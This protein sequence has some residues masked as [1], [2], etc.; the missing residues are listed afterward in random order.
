MLGR[1]SG[2][3]RRSESSETEQTPPEPEET[4]VVNVSEKVAQDLQVELS[5]RG[6]RLFSTTDEG[7][8]KFLEWREVKKLIEAIQS[9]ARRWVHEDLEEA[10]DQLGSLLNDMY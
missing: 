1:I 7:Y 6:L 5:S 4:I 9:E 10:A 3:L 8:G 2:W